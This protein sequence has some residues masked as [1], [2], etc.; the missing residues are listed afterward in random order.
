VPF[1]LRTGKAM[2]EGR[3]VV[4]ITLREPEHQIFPP[5]DDGAGR[6]NELIFE[7]SD[8]PE[9]AVDL[10]VKVPG[11]TSEITRAPLSLDVE[12]ELNEHGLEAYER[13]LHDV[14]LGDQLLFTRADEVERLW[15]CAT[16][17]LTEPPEP[18]SYP[19]GSW[20]PDAAAEL[21]APSGWRLPDDG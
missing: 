21:A 20:G 13:L 5:G 18:Q 17:I 10:R 1:L 8:D 4:T 6:P 16:P 11:P 7:L 12:R 3:R 9:I 15:A 19:R 2:A 14:M